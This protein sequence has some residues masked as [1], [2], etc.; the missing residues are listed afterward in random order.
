MVLISKILNKQLTSQVLNI[1][2]Q[3]VVN[4]DEILDIISDNDDTISY[5]T[6]QNYLSLS[7]E[8]ANAFNSLLIGPQEDLY[9]CSVN[10]DRNS[11][12]FNFYRTVDFNSVTNGNL[13]W[14]YSGNYDLR[15]YFELD[16]SQLF[17]YDGSGSLIEYIM[18]EVSGCPLPANYS[19]EYSTSPEACTGW[20]NYWLSTINQ[21]KSRVVQLNVLISTFKIPPP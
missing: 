8:Y 4:I 3:F 5:A 17:S 15:P 16:F 2:E 18:T 11:I 7:N 10:E 14:I 12:I 20:Q 6:F 19:T 9:P 13:P 21:I 1:T